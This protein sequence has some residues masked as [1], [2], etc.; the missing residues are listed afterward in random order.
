MTFPV[1]TVPSANQCGQIPAL[2]TSSRC[3]SPR[4]SRRSMLAALFASAG[5]IAATLLGPLPALAQ[6]H[7]DYPNK[8]VTIVVPWPPGGPTDIAA[9]P[10]SKGLAD[11]FGKSV[12]VDN[13]AGAAG[14]IGGAIVAKSKGDGYTLMA[15]SS[16][17]VVI[18]PYLYKNQGFDPATELTPITNLLRV[19][20]V[21][22]ANPKVVDATDL[23][24]LLTAI[25]AANGNFSY[26]SSGNGTPQHMTGELFRSVTG[27]QITHVPYKGS[28]P[29]IADVLAGQVPIQF[30]STV[31]IMEHIKSGAVRPLAVTSATRSPLLPDVPTFKELGY[32]AIESY[33]WY[34]LFAPASTPPDLVKRINAAAIEVI[35][36]PE[37]QRVLKDS[38]SDDPASTPE[39]FAAFV[40]AER[41]KWKDI[42][43][44]SGARID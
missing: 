28:A 41:A 3:M 18:N 34:G 23:K 31:A 4:S 25:K 24:G 38:G 12:V 10:L 22:V 7:A 30:D 11:R 8:T 27:I 16:A 1:P 19:P 32:P 37:Y 17:T 2:R 42:V 6:S 39:A 29:A 26:A 36:S 35:R 13:R 43:A 9:R 40:K 14:N 5:A 15:T 33:A 20:L 21:L 44:K